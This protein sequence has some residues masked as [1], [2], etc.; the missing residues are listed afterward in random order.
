MANVRRVVVVGRGH[1]E[2]VPQLQQRPKLARGTQRLPTLRAQPAA[3]DMQVEQVAQLVHDIRNPLSTMA[4]ETRVLQET[5]D[6]ASREELERTLE[7]FQERIQFV[8]RMLQTLMD[9]PALAAAHL[10]V[11][12]EATEL[13]AFVADVIERAAPLRDRMRIFLDAAIGPVTGRIDRLQIERVITNLIGNALK[14]APPASDIVVRIEHED[15]ACI[16]SVIDSGPGISGDEAMF[17]FDKYRRGA[18]AKNKPGLGLGLYISKRIVE[19]HG[20]TIGV[21]PS[22]A[23]GSR[24]YFVLPVQNS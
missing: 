19:A 8:D 11:G 5:I 9:L 15:S 22:D 14:F 3:R 24:F 2:R 1:E 21:E 18:G 6:Q 23:G 10:D 7:R 4:L 13:R 16:V 12:M 20:G 17:I